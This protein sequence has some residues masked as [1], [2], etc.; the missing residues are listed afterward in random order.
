MVIRSSL[1]FKT[2]QELIA[3][4]RANPGKLNFGSAGVGTASHTFGVGPQVF[5]SFSMTHIPY[6]GMAD[7]IQAI[8]GGQLDVG[9]A[10]PSLVINHVRAGTLR[11]LAVTQGSRSEYLPEVPTFKELGVDYVD[12]E[13]YGLVGP[14]GLPTEMVERISTAVAEAMKSPQFIEVMSKTLTSTLYM[15]PARY[16]SFL[17]EKERTWNANLA[18]PK[19]AEL[20][21]Q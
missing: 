13:N 10:I 17:Q 19:F 15:P 6:K 18:N 20:L 11:A 3:F 4:G 16:Q 5:G 7:A 2:A 9:F 14:K 8:I 21:K 12:G 1:P